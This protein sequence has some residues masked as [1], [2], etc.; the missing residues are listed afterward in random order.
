M[1]RNRQTNICM[2][3]KYIY[4]IKIYSYK[5]NSTTDLNRRNRNKWRKKFAYTRIALYYYPCAHVSTHKEIPPAHIWYSLTVINSYSFNTFLFI[6]GFLYSRCCFVM[7]AW[8]H[9]ASRHQHTTRSHPNRTH[10]NSYF[11]LIIITHTQTLYSCHHCTKKAIHGANGFYSIGF[12][13]QHMINDKLY[14]ATSIFL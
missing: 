6:S 11:F 9:R 7:R 13:Q 10:Q 4:G 5:N 8:F 3:N 12:A 1:T 2:Y 14:D